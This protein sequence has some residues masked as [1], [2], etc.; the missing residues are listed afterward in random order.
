MAGAGRRAVR[1]VDALRIPLPDGRRLAARLWL[2]AGAEAD[3]VPALIEYIP[4]RHRD[5]T[6]AR[7]AALHGPIAAAG[8]ACLR[9]DIAGSGDSE[10]L[11]RDEYTAEELADGVAVIAWAARQSWCS[12]RV[13]LIGKSW[14]GF[15]ALQIAALAPPEL[16]AVIAVCASTDR[17]ADD[18]HYKGGCLLG[19]NFSWGA[20]MTSYQSRPPD[21]AS[22]GPHWRRA[23][24]A[25]LRAMPDFAARWMAH[26]ARDAYWRHGSVCEDWRAIRAPVLAVGGWADNYLATV[27]RLVRR[28]EVP[29]AGILGPWG[30]QYPHEAGPGPRI[31]FHGEVIDWLDRWLKGRAERPAP[32][33]LRLFRRASHRPARS[34]HAQP[35]AWIAE[36]AWPPPRST[37]RLL[38]LA[39]GALRDAPPAAGPVGLAASPADAGLA[40]GRYFP[41][42]G[43][44]GELPGDQREDDA[45]AA[46]FDTAPL[47]R[48]LDLVGEPVLE[49]RLVP[50]RPRAQIC[51]RLVELFPDG[52][53]TRL[54]HGLLNLCHAADPARPRALVPGRPLDLRLVLDPLAHRLAAGNRL[55]L[56]ISTGCWP[57][58]WPAPEPVRIVLLSG[59]L[60]LPVHAGAAAPEW[61]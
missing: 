29:A 37:E 18:I 36:A 16:G 5:G 40:Q 60:A 7:D 17:F 1:V 61:R 11:L 15:N 14:G 41:M 26:P 52:A 54:T 34:Q 51:V 49:L 43:T 19:E 20:Q 56:A 45:R 53:G 27:T 57:L 33:P 2:P 44:A 42:S 6:A 48:P 25:R 59:R 23:W 8:Y 39:P 28:L 58:A 55:R 31:D 47:E 38:H 24:L 30:H 9:V 13:G 3:P 10:G 32:P 22:F 35:G 12:G 4:Y 21:P 50:D 46:L